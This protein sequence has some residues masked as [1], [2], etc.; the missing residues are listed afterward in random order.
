MAALRRRI[1]DWP[2]A[3][4]G[5]LALGLLMMLP[6]SALEP[7][8]LTILRPDRPPASLNRADL[9]AMP[10]REVR[11]HTQWTDGIQHFQGP[12]L[13]WLLEGVDPAAT[14]ILRAANDYSVSIPMREIG[15]EV[16]IVAY[17]RN[18]QPMTLRD[19]GP[20]WLI[21]PFDSD[22]AFRTEIIFGR[23][24]WQLI[25]IRVEP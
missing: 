14:V 8:I 23:S 18:G 4:A 1:L 25:E 6:A 5:G 22:P 20:F 15:P 12:A 21:Y 3:L 19:Y 17:A 13:A 16:P 7:G 2:L 10:G 9:A 11:T 24:I